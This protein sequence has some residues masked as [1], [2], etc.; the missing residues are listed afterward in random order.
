MPAPP[1]GGPP[2]YARG[3]DW[4]YL[5]VA[6]VIVMLSETRQRRSF[7]YAGLLNTALALYFIADRRQWFDRTSWGIAIVAAG[8]M[9]LGIGFV[10]HRRAR[11]RLG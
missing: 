1:R 8:L 7:S 6:A 4:A 2:E 3:F 5:A 10:L 9:T 11:R